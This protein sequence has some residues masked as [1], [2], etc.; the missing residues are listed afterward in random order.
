MARDVTLI[1]RFI[2]ERLSFC[3]FT[4]AAQLRR[5]ALTEVDDYCRSLQRRRR[6]RLKVKRAAKAAE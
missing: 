4:G 5:K 1:R 3:S 6:Q 2:A